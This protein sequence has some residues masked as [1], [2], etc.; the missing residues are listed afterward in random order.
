MSALTRTPKSPSAPII[1]AFCAFL[2]ALAAL[3]LTPRAA[4][5]QTMSAE[6]LERFQLRVS[7][8]KRLF[9]MGKYRAS[10]EQ[11]EAARQIYDHSLLR[12]NIAQ[13][14][15]AMG[16]CAQAHDAFS[17]FLALP[18]IDPKMRARAVELLK[19]IETD[20][21]E[22]GTVQ[23]SCA[24]ENI[25][26]T[27]TPLDADGTRQTAEQMACPLSAKLPVGRYEISAAAVDHEPSAQIIE[28]RRDET[29]N[30]RL[31]LE[32]AETRLLDPKTE[33]I[34]IYTT[35]G[36]GAATLAA[37]VIS[38]YTAVGR[39][40][41]LRA[42]QHRQDTRLID[43]LRDEADA[44]STRSAVLYG[45]GALIL[46]GGVTWKIIQMTLSAEPPPRAQTLAAPRAPAKAGALFS[47]DI[48]LNTI[49]TRLQW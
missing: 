38:D 14:Y 44:A 47:V 2:V 41:E 34:L 46:A 23:V 19:D 7:D 16:A 6:Q 20:C 1:R 48:G 43:E 33:E 4:S 21:V 42:A 13:S 37:G 31:N 17:G 12:F 30:L 18:D 45:V 29:Q 36:V 10:I 35:L 26:L 22:E 5:A 3:T 39:L 24:P 27:V 9:E 28:V 15:R 32:R 11:F 8:G 49:S 25:T 40:D